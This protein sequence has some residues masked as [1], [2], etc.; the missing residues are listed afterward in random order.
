[1]MF[2]AYETMKALV[3]EAVN[4][5]RGYRAGTTT[6]AQ[7][8]PTEPMSVDNLPLP[9]VLLSGGA[10]GAIAWGTVFPIDVAKSRIQTKHRYRS[11]SPWTAIALIVKEEGVQT[12]YRGWSAA[13][14]RSFP[15]NASLFFGYEYTKSFLAAL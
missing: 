2:G 9:W 6:S 12:L 1:M 13:V 5:W 11:M 14:L 8:T 7:A 3:C 4:S 15:A 10:A